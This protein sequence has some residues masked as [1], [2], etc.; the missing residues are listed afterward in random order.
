M[1]IKRI[2]SF[3]PTL[4]LALALCI[5]EPLWSSLIL[6]FAV[7]LHEGAHAAAIFAFQAG[8]PEIRG[9][10]C[11]FLMAPDRPLSEKE[12]VLTALAGPLANLVAAT[13]CL[14]ILR[15]GSFHRWCFTML[16][17]NLLTAL[18]NLIPIRGSDGGRLCRIALSHLLGKWGARI[19][20]AISLLLASV[21]YFAAIFLFYRGAVGLSLPIFGAATFFRVVRDDTEASRSI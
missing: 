8:T 9:E 10:A 11:G 15:L 16:T 14:L 12:E 6:L 3:L 20:E 4:F 18:C 17:V 7:I 13:V 1:R 19:A 21:F 2:L 5:G